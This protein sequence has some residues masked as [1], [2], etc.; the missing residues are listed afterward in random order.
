MSYVK[1]VDV[2]LIFGQL[3]PFSEVVL[4]TAMEYI[5]E[6]DGSGEEELSS[7]TVVKLGDQNEGDEEATG[8]EGEDVNKWA[9]KHMYWLKIT[10]EKFKVYKVLPFFQR[11]KSFQHW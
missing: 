1:M 6:G 10:G 9:T 4:L 2:W 5:R 11:R 3:V 8:S 7:P